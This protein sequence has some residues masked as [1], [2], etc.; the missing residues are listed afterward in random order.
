M[1]IKN[2]YRS[3]SIIF[4]LTTGLLLAV[5]PTAQEFLQAIEENN[6]DA[7]A[8]ML[9]QGVDIDQS[10]NEYGETALMI[11]V[12][13]GHLA[14]VE[15]LLESNN[16]AQIDF[17]DEYGFTPLMLSAQYGHAHMVQLLLNRGARI[18][19][20]VLQSDE[21][22]SGLTACMLAAQHGKASVVDLLL[23]HGAIVDHRDTEGWTAL[24]LAVLNCYS[25]VIKTILTHKSN[26]AQIDLQ[27]P[28]SDKHYGGMTAFYIA[29]KEK[30]IDDAQL[31][32][33]HGADYSIKSLTDNNLLEVFETVREK[34]LA[35]VALH[36]DYRHKNKNIALTIMS[37]ESQI[38]KNKIVF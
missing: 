30:R 33:R 31:L 8:V 10:L 25:D 2:I 15:L 11:A 13:L 24:M 16:N 34:A 1:K 20:E 29:M 36:N 6:V 35:E 32:L 26:K 19:F 37:L 9:E 18:D 5:V 22:N 27:V 4:C 38:A 12:K 7:L 3:L 14:M 23:D 28:D 21:D 17:K